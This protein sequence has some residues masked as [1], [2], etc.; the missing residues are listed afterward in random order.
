MK[1]M[2]TFV[3]LAIGISAALI[4]L[5]N[6]IQFRMLGNA[7]TLLDALTKLKV[8]LYVAIAGFV[9]Y[10]IIKIFQTINLR[11]K[12]LNDDT[13][14]EDYEYFEEQKMEPLIPM[15]DSYDNYTP[16]YAKEAMGENIIEK[17]IINEPVYVENKKCCNCKKEISLNAQYCS[18]CGANQKENQKIL[19]PFVK[20]LINVL[21]IVIL[22]LVIYFLLNMLFD[23]KEKQDPNFKSPFKV[24]MTK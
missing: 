3:P 16:M 15:E 20:N 6:V 22:I 13:L 18:Y 2:L 21:E 14:D 23:F 12:D 17:V 4:Y 5:F 7:V 24:S 10:F 1:K 19:N 8:Y 11:K 9:I